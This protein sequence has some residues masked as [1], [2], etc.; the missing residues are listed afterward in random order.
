[1]GKLSGLRVCHLA[2]GDLWAGAEVQVAT[3]LGALKDFPGLE[4]SALLLNQGR[5]ADELAAQGIAVTIFD[6]SRLGFFQLLRAVAN[7]LNHAQ[8][9]ILHSHRYKE[10]ILGALAAKLS[11]GPLLIQTYHGLEENLPGWAGHKMRVF[12]TINKVVGRIMATGI[13]G[14]SSEITDILRQRYPSADVRCIKN[15]IDLNRVTPTDSR[16]S[17]REKLG[18]PIGAFVVGVVGRLMPIKGIHY[19]IEAMVR[20]REHHGL[21]ENRLV[22][23]GDGPLRV[24]LERAVQDGGLTSNVMFLGVRSDV[25]DVMAAFDVLALP[26]LHE[27]IPMVLLEAMAIGI[28]IVASNVGGIPEILKD[29]TEAFLVPS[30]DVVVLASRLNEYAESSDLRDRLSRAAKARVQIEFSIQ[31]SAMNMHEMY[32]TIAPLRKVLQ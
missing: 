13:V 10:H 29:E 32:Q 25:Y 11:H 8:P 20:L 6:E 9:H 7:Y 15:G 23:V 16:S 5:L 27:G 19:L 14:V 24:E 30:G 22:I 17:M 18:I 31:K 4:L 3:L 1:M 2:S 12:D 26:S 28:P 21:E